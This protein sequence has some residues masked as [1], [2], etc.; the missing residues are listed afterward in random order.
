MNLLIKNTGGNS[1]EFN[2]T[3]QNNQLVQLPANSQANLKATMTSVSAPSP[4]QLEIR[5]TSGQVT[6]TFFVTVEWS[7][8]E[9]TQTLNLGNGQ[10]SV[11]T[12]GMAHNGTVPTNDDMLNTPV[13]KQHF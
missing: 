7:L 2:F 5:E 9:A 10:G 1:I 4:V 11:S 13:G 12:S 8:S 6:D 3:P